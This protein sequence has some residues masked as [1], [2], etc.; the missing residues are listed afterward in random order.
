M[1]FLLNR[2]Y[3]KCVLVARNISLY[4]KL[5]VICRWIYFSEVFESRIRKST[6][7]GS[8]LQNIITDD[9]QFPQGIALGIL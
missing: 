2:N 6:F 1:Y 5:H 9:I 8:N 3:K 7:D 4:L